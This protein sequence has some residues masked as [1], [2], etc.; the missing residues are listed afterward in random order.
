[1]VTDMTAAERMVERLLA[2]NWDKAAALAHEKSRARLARE[3]LRRTAQWAV[4]VGAER[5]WPS[6]DLASGVDPEVAVDP[7]LLA[8]L[9]LDESSMD[10]FPVPTDLAA[11]IVRWA[12]LGDLPR[13][14]FPQLDDPYEPILELFDRGGGFA[15]GPGELDLG[16]ISIQ[17][18]SVTDRATLEPLPIDAATLD[19]L[20]Q[21]A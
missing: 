16:F 5:G 9:E 12:A 15:R 2:V 11:A 13:Q 8:R 3:F 1:M 19:A 21:E 17:L 14:R 6:S 10:L 18:R 7:A 4:A 20:D